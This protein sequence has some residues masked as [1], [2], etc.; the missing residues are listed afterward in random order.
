VADDQE[1][2]PS[3]KWQ[4]EQEPKKRFSRKKGGFSNEY[5]GIIMFDPHYKDTLKMSNNGLL[6]IKTSTI[7]PQWVNK[8]P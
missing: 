8:K 3:G 4:L 1:C 6:G 5:E 2:C 7:L